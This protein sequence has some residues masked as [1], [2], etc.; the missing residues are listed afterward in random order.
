MS[1]FF[2]QAVAA[3]RGV[4]AAAIG[5]RLLRFDPIEAIVGKAVSSALRRQWAAPKRKRLLDRPATGLTL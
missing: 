5:S 3:L 1:R 4:C 2:R